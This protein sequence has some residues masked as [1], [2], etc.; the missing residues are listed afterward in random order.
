MEK[1]GEHSTN[2]FFFTLVPQNH[3]GSPIFKKASLVSTGV[4]NG[5]SMNTGACLYSQLWPPAAF[6]PPSLSGDARCLSECLLLSE[7]HRWFS[8]FIFPTFP[9][10]NHRSRTIC[11]PPTSTWN[12]DRTFCVLCAHAHSCTCICWKKPAFRG[13]QMA[14]SKHTGYAE[15]YTESHCLELSDIPRGIQEFRVV[16]SQREWNQWSNVGHWN[17]G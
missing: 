6:K 8:I 12:S 10:P 7:F 2:L 15:S 14:L 3:W 16:W 13:S 4:R 9:P 11:A 5:T 17:Q 1:I